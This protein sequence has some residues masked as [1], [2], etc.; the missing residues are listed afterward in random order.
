MRQRLSIAEALLDQAVVAGIGN[1]ARSEILFS[2]RIDPR[3]KVSELGD[4]EM[5][6]LLAAI[7]DTL[8]ASYN[9]GGRW[10]CVVYRTAGGECINCG[11]A[12][13]SIKLP[14]SR[15]ATYFCPRCQK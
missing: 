12:I 11:G 5:P 6:R 13:R 14:P 15:R 2:A 7:H 9:N 3:A 8:W 10:K 4:C 1:I